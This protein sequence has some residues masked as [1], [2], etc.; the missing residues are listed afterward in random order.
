MASSPPPSTDRFA[1]QFRAEIA[2]KLSRM[3]KSPSPAAFNEVKIFQFVDLL[4]ATR[5]VANFTFTE[6]EKLSGK[7]L[8]QG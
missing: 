3:P 6:R 7:T 1:R 5:R 4:M 8:A 2:M